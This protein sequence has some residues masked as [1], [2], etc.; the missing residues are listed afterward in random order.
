[1]NRRSLQLNEQFL[2]EHP[3]PTRVE[4]AIEDRDGDPQ[5]AT[6]HRGHGGP[7]VAPGVITETVRGGRGR[8]LPFDNVESRIPILATN[9]IDATWRRD[10]KELE[11]ALTV[12]DSH[13]DGCTAG[14][15]GG[16]LRVP[17]IRRGI[18][19]E[20]WSE[21]LEECLPLDTV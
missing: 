17:L 8:G 5:P 18:I 4:T 3:S 11:V 15:G 21:E 20:G 7:F 12:E 16:H 10:Y 13:A 19:P 6:V 9:C 2:A 1:M 14:R